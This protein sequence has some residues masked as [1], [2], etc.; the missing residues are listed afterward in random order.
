MASTPQQRSIGMYPTTAGNQDSSAQL[1]T[2][3]S[4]PTGLD[5]APTFELD[6]L[7]TFSAEED[8]VIIQV[9]RNGQTKNITYDWNDF[10]PRNQQS[11]VNGTYRL[12]S[13][14][15]GYGVTG[16]RIGLSTTA[17]VEIA[18]AGPVS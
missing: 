13:H 16:I 7:A 18:S 11:Y 9:Q 10:R 17:T 14:H 8:E 4:L 5:S 6:V 1:T 15:R 3:Y 2:T 12:I